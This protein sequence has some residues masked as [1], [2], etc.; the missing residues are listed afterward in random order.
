MGKEEST[1]VPRPEKIE[2]VRQ[3]V[4]NENFL[5]FRVDGLAPARRVNPWIRTHPHARRCHMNL[6]SFLDE[7]GVNY[8]LSHHP[9]TYR[10]QDLAQIEHM[11]GRNV[12]KPVLVKAD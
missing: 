10:S 8:R 12:V 9:E 2:P 7:Q 5:N 6:P 1:K 11:S 3:V 4:F